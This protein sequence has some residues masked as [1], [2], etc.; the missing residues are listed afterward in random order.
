ML[1]IKNLIKTRATEVPITQIVEL[2]IVTLGMLKQRTNNMILNLPTSKF[3][4][5]GSEKKQ[6]LNL[7]F[8]IT[9]TAFGIGNTKAMRKSENSVVLCSLEIDLTGIPTN[10]ILTLAHGAFPRHSRSRD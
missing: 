10:G 1:N 9:A 6:F 8:G 5:H 2:A 3:S 7:I 4:P